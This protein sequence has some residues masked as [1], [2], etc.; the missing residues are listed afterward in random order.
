M[1]KSEIDIVLIRRIRMFCYRVYIFLFRKKKKSNKKAQWKWH[2]Y[3]LK[4]GKGCKETGGMPLR[5]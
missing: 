5:I 1:I 4:N 2:T 3:S